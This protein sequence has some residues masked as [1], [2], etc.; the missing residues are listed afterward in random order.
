MRLVRGI[1]VLSVASVGVLGLAACSS[2]TDAPASTSTAADAEKA[3]AKESS[4]ELT[5]ENFAKRVTAAVVDAGSVTIAM[6]TEAAGATMDATGDIVM[7]DGK[8]QLAMT[9]AVP[10]S[11]EMQIRVVDGLIYLNLGAL[12][13]GK[14]ATIDPADTSNPMASSFEDLAAQMDP[15]T[16]VKELDGA[17]TSIEKDGE[18]VDVDGVKAQPYTIVVDTTKLSG[19][20]KDEVDAA[21]GAL[22]ETLTYQYWI[23]ADDRMRK[24]VTSVQGATVE[25]TFTNWGEDLQVVAPSAEEITT[26]PIF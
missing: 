3:P 25:M 26:E 1:A 18:P 10:G 13:Q 19:S 5:P 22:P 24:V 9:M 17:I 2:G 21:G 4:S 12:S 14:F 6:S 23:D 20:M 15:T 7:K 16:S 8:Q 11:E